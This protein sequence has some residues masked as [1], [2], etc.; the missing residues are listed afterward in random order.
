[1]YNETL[2]LSNKNVFIFDLDDTISLNRVTPSY[3]Q[4]YEFKIKYFLEYLKEKNKKLIIVSHNYDPKEVLERKSWLHY[5]DHIEGPKIISET[6][7][8]NNYMHKDVLTHVYYNFTISICENKGYMIKNVLNKLNLQKEEAVFFD[9][10][11]CHVN[12]VNLIG[13]QS[14]LVNRNKGIM[15][16]NLKV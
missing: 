1:M 10:A 13:V 6:E 9:D 12:S 16:E 2:D 4:E 5:F 11:L 3:K 15:T 14:I 7:N 8:L